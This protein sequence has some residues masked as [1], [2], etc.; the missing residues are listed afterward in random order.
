[1]RRRC[2]VGAVLVLGLFAAA[3][4]TCALGACLS[5]DVVDLGTDFD[6]ER[7]VAAS[8]SQNPP[9][10]GALGDAPRTDG[11]DSASATDATDATDAI[12]EPGPRG[13]VCLI[14][15]SFEVYLPGDAQANQPVQSHPLGWSVCAGALATS[16]ICGLRPTDQD[17]YVGLSVGLAPYLNNP[18]SIDTILCDTLEAGVTYALSVDVGL[19]TLQADSGGPGEP[20]FLQIWGATTACMA[21]GP[22]ELLWSSPSLLNACMWRRVCKSFT[23]SAPYDHLVMIPGTSSSSAFRVGPTYIVVDNLVT[24][25]ACP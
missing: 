21:Q 16:Q 18:A 13:T 3:Y 1:M 10:S 2:S 11:T 19:D 15:K 9:E 8:G 5:G 7:G 23:P 6:A 14:D 20:P 4:L 12:D 25:S 24:P 22:Y 17:S